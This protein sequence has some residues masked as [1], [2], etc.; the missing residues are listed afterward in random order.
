MS[1]KGKMSCSSKSRHISIEIFLVE[2][3]AK[4]GKIRVKNCLNNKILADFFTNPLQ[5]SKFN[6]SRRVIMGWDNIATLWD[7]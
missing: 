2:N 5:G 4:Q 1:K 3:M 6:M 7:D